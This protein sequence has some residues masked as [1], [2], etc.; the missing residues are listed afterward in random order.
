MLFLLFGLLLV[1]S[2]LVLLVKKSRESV[3]LLGMC[4]SLLVQCIGLMTFIA[5]KGGLSTD[6]LRFLFFSSSFKNWLQYR[7]ITLNTMGYLIALGRYLFPLFLMELALHYSMISAI[8][9]HPHVKYIVAVL[10]LISLI[11]YFPPVFNGLIAVNAVVRDFVVL[12]SLFWVVA[13]VLVA[14]ALLIFE[15][16][17]ITMHFCRRQFSQIVVCMVAL[18]GL[19]LLYCAQD[20]GQ[21]YRFYSYNYVWYRGIGYMMYAPDMVGYIVLVVSNVICAV[22]GFSSLVRYTQG[23][24]ASNRDEIVMESKFDV[25]RSG[26]SV[27]VHSIK[28]QLLANR[29]LE[30][31]LFQEL[32][33]PQPDLVRIRAGVNALHDN[34]EMLI[35][36]SEELY[37]TVKSKS[38]QLVPVKLTAL[39]KTALERFYKKYPDGKVEVHFPQETEVLADKNYFSEALYNLLTNA[40]EANVEAGH[41]EAPVRM[42]CQEERLYTVLVVTDTG[43]GI[44]RSEQKKIFEP[45]YSSKN[46][47][48]NWGMGL[49]H[50]RMIVRAHLGSLRMESTPGQ[51][52]SFFIL[53]PKYGS[54]RVPAAYEKAGTKRWKR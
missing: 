11:A 3:F 7:L 9:R 29:V 41:T 13:Y 45:F 14:L 32:N 34:N 37:R 25:A 18:S 5:K 26:A 24:F 43:C 42:L 8:R 40:W 48:Y 10:P 54:A 49:Y 39:A 50:V 44:T 47:N 22:L 51:G 15:F 21:V 20:P 35:T 31:R 19:Y 33:K 36:R 38:V 27:F 2:V 17:S 23:S 16:F 52:A 28:N 6:V 53:L 46:S 4:L 1:A 30:K 12:F